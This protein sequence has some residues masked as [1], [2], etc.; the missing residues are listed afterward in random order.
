MNTDPPEKKE[1]TKDKTMANVLT[2]GVT[3]AGEDNCKLAI[4]P[5]QVKARKGNTTVHTYAFLDPG[6]TA[7]FCTVGLMAKLNLHGRRSNILLRTMGQKKVIET[8]IVSGLEVA[9]L[10]SNDFCHLPGMYTQKNMPVN[11]GNIPQQNDIDQWPH[12][13]NIHLPELDSEVDLLIGSDVPKALEPLDVIQSVGHGPYAVKTLLG[14][15]VNG[16]LGGKTD[17]QEISANRISV[18]KLDQLW[19]Q[20]FKTDFPECIRDDKEHSREDQQFLN[21]VSTSAKL[22]NGHYC[23]ALPLKERDIC[24]PDN[25]S[26]AEQR[27]LNLKKRF[28]KDSS[29]HSE[30][31][32]FVSDMISKGYAEKVPDDV[33]DCSDGG[34]WYLPHHGT[35]HRR[36]THRRTWI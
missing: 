17:A 20:Q 33:L 36:K 2:G 16:P 9:G 3:G 24:M 4:V 27:T 22:V 29:F 26:V 35:H 5:V 7:S 34:K 18:V 19:E 23:I 11:K 28:K 8:H 13:R 31:T 21:L 15:T 12:L 30:Y 1:T 10:N 32:K 6:S 14:W 25:R